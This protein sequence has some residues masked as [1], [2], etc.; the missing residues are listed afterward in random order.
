MPVF[1]CVVFSFVYVFVQDRLAVYVL[2]MCVYVLFC[3]VYVLC[4]A[5]VYVCVC[6][7]VCVCACVCVYVAFL[8]CESLRRV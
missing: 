1:V 3:V 7:C 4:C 5:C 8:G 2:W 6:V